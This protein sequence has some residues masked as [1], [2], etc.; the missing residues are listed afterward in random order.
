MLPS[1]GTRSSADPSA[2]PGAD[3]GGVPRGAAGGDR[4]ATAKLLLGPAL[5]GLVLWLSPGEQ[6][7]VAR[8]AG[9]A[10]WMAAWW[11]T[12]AVPVA[13]TALLPLVLFPIA[14][15]ARVPVVAQDYGRET[16]FLFLGGF[17]LALGLQESGAHRRY[18]LAVVA[19]IGSRPRRLVLG[20]MLA[21]GLI[22]MWISNTSTTLLLLPITLSVLATARE[23]GADPAEVRR[24]GVPLMLAIAHGS[25]IGGLATP[26]GTPTNLAFRQLFVQLF[27]GAPEV[28]FATW[29]GIGVPLA[30]A[31][32]I[33]GWWL[34][35]RVVF[36]LPAGELLGGRDV[37]A[38]LRAELGPAGRDELLAGGLFVA[39]AGLWVT[40]KGLQFGSFLLPGWQA[41]APLGGRV[42]DHVVAIGLAVLL[43][44]LPS[45]RRPGERLLE[46]EATTRVPWG[47]LLL[48]GGGFALATGFESSGL[49]AWASSLFSALEG[50][51]PLVVL[52]VSCAALVLLS[53]FASNTAT[54]QIALPILAAAAV[55]LRMDPRA[56]MIPATLS[57]SCAFMLPVGTPPSAIVFGSGYLSMKD[58]LRAGLLFNLLGLALVIGVFWLLAG[59]VLGLSLQPGTLPAWAAP[60]R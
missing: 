47:I 31:F 19:A 29:M 10:A 56:L 15:L 9:V 21:A 40:G 37:I 44:V 43:F 39:A 60:A 58:M 41:W 55:S 45:A 48:F 4:W 11:V 1:S 18:A 7:S 8:M 51:P 24:L 14:G 42:D 57:A 38:R 35:V 26:V 32:L 13:V 49:S 54:A 12:E 20:F 53:E 28:G 33:A 22:S 23:Q 16:I 52:A 46:W 30:A 34:L 27:P 50:S 2:D 5:A 6:P 3:P 59:P 36:P 17:L 25:T